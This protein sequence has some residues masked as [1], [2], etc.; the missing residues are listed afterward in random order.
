MGLIRGIDGI[1]EEFKN[2]VGESGSP[3]VSIRQELEIAD[4]R[5]GLPTYGQGAPCPSILEP[6][7]DILNCGDGY[8]IETKE[9]DE[10]ANREQAM[11]Y[12]VRSDFLAQ[13]ARSPF[14]VSYDFVIYNALLDY[15][16][17]PVIK[18]GKPRKF[19]LVLN[20]QVGQ[21]QWLRIRWHVPAGWQVEPGHT[22]AAFL[23]HTHM[24]PTVL[25]FA[26]TA[27]RLEQDRYDLF[28][29]IVSQGRPTKGIIPIVLLHSCEKAQP[30]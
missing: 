7:C 2:P 20:N 13:L 21:Q 11:N 8:S 19:R 27:D 17:D 29:E 12:W 3:G 5:N 26:V 4:S 14:C 1:P 25:D 16:Q 28:V 15:G 10:L 9:K 18:A 24:G 22:T 30:E 23:D 6:Y